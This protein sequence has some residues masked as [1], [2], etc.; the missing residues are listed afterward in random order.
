M[1]GADHTTRW[2]LGILI[3]LML[4]GTWGPASGAKSRERA[5][6]IWVHPDIANLAVHRIALLPAASFEDDL[7]DVKQETVV[8]RAFAEAFHKSGH[9]WTSSNHSGDLLRQAF[10]NTAIDRVKKEVLE[11]GRV[12]SLT[13]IKS[14]GALGTD[15]LLSLRID[16]LERIHGPDAAGKSTASAQIVAAMVDSKGRL[17]WRASGGETV[18]GPYIEAQ[19]VPR[20]APPAYDE[21]LDALFERWVPRFP[22]AAK[23]PTTTAR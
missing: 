7:R 18:Q 1:R 21:V 16:R 9:V 15:A 22:A 6:L 17:V 20:S 19:G 5:D 23:S 12:D 2:V 8:Q 14:C 13:A 11:S 4:F 3:S 10:G